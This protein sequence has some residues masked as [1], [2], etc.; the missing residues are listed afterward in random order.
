MALEL[1][2][3][4]GLEPLRKGQY[5]LQQAGVER[6]LGQVALAGRRVGQAQVLGDRA[7]KEITGLGDI[8]DGR[9]QLVGVELAGIHAV[10][11]DPAELRFVETG[12]QLQQGRL[13]RPVGAGDGDDL[14]GVDLRV[15]GQERRLAARVVAQRDA[16]EADPTLEAAQALDDRAGLALH[17][18]AHQGVDLLQALADLLQ[19]REGQERQ[20]KGRENAPHQ[21]HA[22]DQGAQRHRLVEDQQCADPQGGDA[23]QQH[24]QLRERPQPGRKLSG[25]KAGQGRVG[26]D[27]PEPATPYRLHRQSLDGP[28]A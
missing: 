20:L 26:G 24:Q 5:L 9:A 4:A 8:A 15:H 18:L 10:D 17:R 13:A 12:D 16:L 27:I 6:R 19:S 2:G 11:E 23:A 1:I 3:Q 22:G 28:H 14:A 7:V 25:A 21:R